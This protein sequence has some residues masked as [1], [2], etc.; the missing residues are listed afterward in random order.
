MLL[1]ITNC[2]NNTDDD[3]QYL[4]EGY[5]SYDDYLDDSNT[6]PVLTPEQIVHQLMLLRLVQGIELTGGSM[7]V[8]IPVVEIAPVAAAA[9]GAHSDIST[10]ATTSDSTV[11]SPAGARPVSPEPTSGAQTS[12]EGDYIHSFTL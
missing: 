2:S 10:P 3:N 1:F 5:G 9:E 12:V 6:P 8:V 11:Q 7:P 4:G